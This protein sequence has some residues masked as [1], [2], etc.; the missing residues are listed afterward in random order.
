MSKKDEDG[1]KKDNEK[2]EEI[3]RTVK[4]FYRCKVKNRHTCQKVMDAYRSFTQNRD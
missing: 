2:L 4:T 1:N 3:Q